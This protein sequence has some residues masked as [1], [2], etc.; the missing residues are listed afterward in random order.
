MDWS[1]ARRPGLRP[2]AFIEPCIPT[3]AKAAP[4]GPAWVHEIKY[5]GYRLMVWRDGERVRLFT[6]RGYDW[7]HRFPRIVN[8]ARKL[9]A[10]RFLID[11]EAVVCGDDGVSDFD[12]LHSGE[13]DASVILYA[14]DLLAIDG[15]DMRPERL[16]DR[17]GKLRLL[18]AHPEGIQFSDHHQGDGDVVF[19]HACQL[20]LEG[21]VSKRRD[22]LYSSGRSKSWLKIKNPDSPA[23][24]RLEDEWST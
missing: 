13:H 14:F 23:M 24:R 17:R 20:G 9:R 16:D 3:L 6:R 4:T 11:G 5:D 15:A 21:I 22:S 10:T 7:T 8:S 2:A 18:L 12:K 1:P 19:R